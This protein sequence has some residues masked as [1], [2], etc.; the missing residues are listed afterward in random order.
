MFTN[1]EL[2]AGGNGLWFG[3]TSAAAVTLWLFTVRR[4]DVLLPEVV[5]A[6]RWAAFGFTFV[7]LHRLFWNLAI[8]Y[9]GPAQSDYSPAFLEVKHWTLLIVLG[10]A[11]CTYRTIRPF[12]TSD[13]IFPEL[14]VSA[15]I[16]FCIVVSIWLA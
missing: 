16:L 2:T 12:K 11:I 9:G 6:G 10:M 5:E 7:A 4:G 15:W 3:F 14:G 8:F 1:D 13:A